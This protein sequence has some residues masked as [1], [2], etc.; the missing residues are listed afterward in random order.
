MGAEQREGFDL[1]RHEAVGGQR[2]GHI[3]TQPQR[4]QVKSGW[5]DAVG[6]D[7]GA[8]LPICRRPRSTPCLASTSRPTRS[9]STR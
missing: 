1:Q 5:F 4:R 7:L 9:R 6:I 8:Q 2:L 3:E